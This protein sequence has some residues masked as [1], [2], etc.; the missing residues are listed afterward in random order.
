[1]SKAIY[2]NGV[3]KPL[4]KIDIPEGEIVE[5]EIK[6]GSIKWRG[7]LKDLKISSVDLQHKIKEIWRKLYVSD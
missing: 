1:M 6:R 3:L 2:K 7:A 5:I 4:E